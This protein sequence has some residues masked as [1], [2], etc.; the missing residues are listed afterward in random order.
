MEH[1]TK[2]GQ[3]VGTAEAGAASF[4]DEL[5]AEHLAE[6]LYA[7]RTL[8]REVELLD[9]AKGPEA[10]LARTSP[11]SMSAHARDMRPTGHSELQGTA[12]RGWRGV[13][14]GVA[15]TLVCLAC[16]EPVPDSS[17]RVL[18]QWTVGA[19]PI[20]SIGG[21]L[22]DRPDH[23]LH[24]VSGAARLSDGRI[25]VATRQSAE[26]KFFGPDGAHIR[27]VGGEGD[28]PGEMRNIMQLVALPGDT[29]LVL[30]FRP[31]LTWFSATGD[32]LQSLPVDLANVGAARCRSGEG[33]WHVLVDGSI[34]VIL[35]A[36]F[37]GPVCPP[38]PPSPYRESALIGR[39]LP[40]TGHF[41]T[42]AILPGTERN[43]GNFRVFG[44]SLL[45]AFSEN[46]IFAADTG[47]DKIL[48]F[49]LK[50]DTLGILPTPWQRTPVPPSH[51]RARTRDRT[52]LDGSIQRGSE[53]L[54]PDLYPSAGRLMVSRLEQ[55]WVMEY[56]GLSQPFSS[57]RLAGTYGFL[58]DPEG[59]R[60][61]VLDSDG[62]LLAEVR[63]PSGL[64]PLEIGEG[65]VLG[66][67][68]DTLDVETVS[69]HE[70]VRD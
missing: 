8:D 2:R 9:G 44:L 25:V 39:W 20:V 67:S 33:N 22:E 10:G 11:N 56:P 7:D 65:Y 55:L 57:W 14:I 5:R 30:S 13:A 41:D 64:F 42:I 6:Q 47:D 50:G 34:V 48:A 66:V 37:S 15:L 28:G 54:Y 29:L 51:K 58:V 61:R 19:E 12:M 45:L 17:R 69:L 1:L 49:D 60:W 53:Y 46:R 63:T 68:R 32:Y 70:L 26:L 36:L 27:T 21:L 35:E 31:G 23:H 43:S 16:G 59:A 3:R 38:R 4:R 18:E 62:T 24:G 52:L 40:A